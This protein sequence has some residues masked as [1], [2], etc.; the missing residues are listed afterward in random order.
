M[1]RLFHDLTTKMSLIITVLLQNK[2]FLVESWFVQILKDAPEPILRFK[3]HD[4]LV[5]L[6]SGRFDRECA[7]L[8][9]KASA[10]GKIE[11]G[12]ENGKNLRNLNESNF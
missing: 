3:A 9:Y 11:I 5:R 6:L 12:A 2:V 4:W 10:S 1:S 7:A 8:V